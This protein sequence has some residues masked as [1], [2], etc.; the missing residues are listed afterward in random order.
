MSQPRSRPPQFPIP[1]SPPANRSTKRSI[2]LT[3]T[4]GEAGL[5]NRNAML[6]STQS[7]PATQPTKRSI[8]LTDTSGEA[9][10][11]NRR[12]MLASTQGPNRESDMPIPPMPMSGG[13][14]YREG[15]INSRPL[16]GG[17]ASFVD[18]LLREIGRY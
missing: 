15:M 13:G 12:A 7:P 4:S 6:A 2:R 10:L 11:V 17:N 18:W 16:S 1:Q 14:M 9:G 8:R 5:V 3:D